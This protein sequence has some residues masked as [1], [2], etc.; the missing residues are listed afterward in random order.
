MKNHL[1][2]T[3][4]MM[5]VI[6]ALLI[7]MLL[8]TAPVSAI[9]VSGSKYMDSIPP[10]GTATHKMTVGIGADEKPTDVLVEVM[11]FGQT[12]ER[13]YTGLEPSRDVN[14]YSARTFISLDRDRIHLEPGTKEEITA[15]ITLPGNVG[16]GGRYAIIYIH[17]L[18]GKGASFTTAIC[19]PVMITGSGTTITET[20]SITGID[21]GDVLI[22]Q[23]IVITTTFKNTGNH[24]YY[25]AWNEVR[26]TNATGNVIS[27]GSTP[28]SVHAII[29]GNTVAFTI[30][31]DV[32]DLPIGTYAISSKVLLEGG[33][34]LD[35][36]T[37]TFEV[38]EEYIPP[39]IESSIRLTPGSS[40]L[41]VS[42][43]GRY[44]ITFPQGA[45]LSEVVVTLKPYPHDR[46][47]PAPNGAGLGATCFE[48]TGLSGLLSK[49]ATVLITYSAD[50]LTAAGGDTSQLKLA[51]WDAAQGNW[52]MLPTQVN[53]QDMTLTTTTNH[54]SVWTVMVSS[55]TTKP[56]STAIPL[57]AVLS[58][59]ALI[60]TTIIY[61]SI[62][63][64]WK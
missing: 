8:C 17:A 36:K 16:A 23:P 62:A 47:H 28:P 63:R 34:V 54:L 39:P 29:P 20:G 58:V 3:H 7:L 18:P 48:I 42:P 60:F 40:G 59:S 27:E 2:R 5:I 55:P 13:I 53:A 45:V 41:L 46:L 32:K 19:V 4:V 64:R 37:A 21:V 31:P 35:E 30:R 12:M 38:K 25:H 22:G 14:S 9:G 26:L 24:H 57:P 33:R 11:G 61:C 15:T 10:G 52:V 1:Q 56:T 43:D 6:T 50:D 51:Y 44:S 49:D